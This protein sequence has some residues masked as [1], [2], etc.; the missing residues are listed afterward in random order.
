MY[1]GRSVRKGERQS[2]LLVRVSCTIS[3][4]GLGIGLQ[5]YVEL[6]ILA[7]ISP[8]IFFDLPYC[9]TRYSV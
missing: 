8:L 7:Y 6:P 5:T 2:L 1:K 4:S 9:I 3:L